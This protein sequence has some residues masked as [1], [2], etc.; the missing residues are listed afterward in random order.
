LSILQ[1]PPVAGT[2]LRWHSSRSGDAGLGDLRFR[3]LYRFNLFNV[4][5]F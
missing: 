4:Q 1:T 2:M 5:I 3:H